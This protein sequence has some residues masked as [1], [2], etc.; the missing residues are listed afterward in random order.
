MTDSIAVPTLPEII[1]ATASPRRHALLRSMGVRFRAWNTGSEERCDPHDPVK[2]SL[3]NALEKHSAAFA[4]FGASEWIL[5]ADTVVF[6]NGTVLGK[7]ASLEEAE[8]MLL[9]YSGRT[10][11]VFTSIAVSPP[12]S[13]TQTFTAAS[14]VSFRSYGAAEVARCISQVNPMDKAGAYDLSDSSRELIASC[15]GSFS[16]IA[17]L[18]CEL[19]GEWLAAHGYFKREGS[20]Y[21]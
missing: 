9:S 21:A 1:A 10:Q 15:S 19:L 20:L 5:A 4:A 7:P 16:N 3:R 18:P 12:Q 13:P 11:T 17:G 14:S 2:T 8:A 6:F